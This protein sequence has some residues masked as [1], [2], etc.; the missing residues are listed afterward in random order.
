MIRSRVVALLVL[1]SLILAVAGRSAAQ[2]VRYVDENG[3][4]HYAQNESMVPEQYRGKLQ[5]LGNLPTVRVEGSQQGGSSGGG[6]RSD[7]PIRSTGSMFDSQPGAVRQEDRKEVP[8]NGPR[9]CVAGVNKR[10][11]SPGHWSDEGTCR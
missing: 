7:I 3:S 9:M 4:T 1:G 8:Y 2:P 11:T 10:M 6:F 5:G